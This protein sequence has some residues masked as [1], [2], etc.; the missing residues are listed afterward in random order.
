MIIHEYR[1]KEGEGKFD[2]TLLLPSGASCLLSHGYIN[3][4]ISSQTKTATYDS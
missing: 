4:N 1:S 2:E 3:P